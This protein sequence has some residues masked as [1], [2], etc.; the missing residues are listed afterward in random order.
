M[1][2]SGYWYLTRASIGFTGEQ[3]DQVV[4]GPSRFSTPQAVAA[5]GAIRGSGPGCPRLG[6]RAGEGRLSGPGTL[7]RSPAPPAPDT[8]RGNPPADA[9]CT[10]IEV[11]KKSF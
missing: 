3:I 4:A 2:K 9:P 5:A 7:C 10:V 8:M 6:S 1:Y 11:E